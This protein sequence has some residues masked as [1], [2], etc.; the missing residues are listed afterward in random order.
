L[1]TIACGCF[2]IAADIESIREWIENC[3]NGLLCDADSPMSLAQ[4]IL[5]ALNDP[6]LRQ[7]ARQYN[8]M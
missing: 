4:A 6:E 5:G 3:V 7:R 2:P 1:K 8:T